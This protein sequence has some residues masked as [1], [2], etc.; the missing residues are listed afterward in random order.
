MALTDGYEP[1]FD[2]DYE[3]GRQGEM[4][5]DSYIDALKAGQARSEV[6][7]K[8]LTDLHFYFEQAQNPRRSGFWKP[9]GIEKTSAEV[10]AFGI[11]DSDVFVLFPVEGIRRAI[12]AGLGIDKTTDRGDNP[13]SGRL[14]TLGPLVAWLDNDAKRG[15]RSA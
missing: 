5:L 4:V 7:R 2:I 6:K 13:T 9:S 8:R 14:L 12:S 3:Y 1:R 15:R 10:I 11:G